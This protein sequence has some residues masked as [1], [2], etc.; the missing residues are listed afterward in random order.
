MNTTEE[1]TKTLNLE[2]ILI[3]YQF[4]KDVVAHTPLQKNDRLSEQYDCQVYVK[5]EV[6]Q[7]VRSFKLRG[8]YYKIKTIEREAREKGVV[9]ASAGNHAQGVAY[10]CANLGIQGTIF[11]PQTTPKQKINQVKC[12]DVTI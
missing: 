11:M 5:R 7:H 6:L 9:C 1:K 8:A 12:L 3:S 4:L 2:D 10:A